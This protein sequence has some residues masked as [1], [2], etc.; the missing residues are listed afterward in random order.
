MFHF[1]RRHGDGGQGIVVV[2][3]TAVHDHEVA[4]IVAVID[5]LIRK[6]R[7]GQRLLLMECAH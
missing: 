5:A 1:D 6:T 7:L 4:V 2:I 3:I